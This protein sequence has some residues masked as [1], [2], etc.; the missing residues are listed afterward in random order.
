MTNFAHRWLPLFLLLA[1]TWMIPNLLAAETKN[2]EPGKIKP[3]RPGSLDDSGGPDGYGYRY[4]DNLNGDT[5][6]YNWIELRGDPAAEWIPFGEDD[7]DSVLPVA[8]GFHFPFYGQIFDTVYLSTNGNLQFASLL[9]AYSNECLPAA[10]IPGPA[11]FAYWDD[12]DLSR[13][14]YN[15]GGDVT[16]GIRR[17]TEG[18]VIEFDSVGHHG[19]DGTS[20]K[21][22]AFL[23]TDGSVSL[24]YKRMIFGSEINTQTIGIQ[25]GS[26]GPALQYVC[27][28]EG[29][30]PQD[31]LAILFYRVPTGTLR[32]LVRDT[33][34]N[35]VS[36]ADARIVELH[37]TAIT[38]DDGAYLFPSVPAGTYSVS[39]Y[40]IGYS[41]YTAGPV[42]ILA[43]DTTTLNVNLTFLGVFSFPSSDVPRDIADF[44]T[45]TSVLDVDTSMQIGDLDVLLN[46]QH[47]YDSDLRISLKAP[48][49]DTVVLTNREGGT[50]DNYINSVF[51]D[52]ADVPISAGVPPFTGRFR[53]EEPLAR[54]NGMNVQ[55]QWIL[56]VEDLAAGDTGILTSWEMDVTP[57]A[58]T[59]PPKSSPAPQ[60]FALLGNFPNPFNSTTEIRFSLPRTMPMELVLYNLLGQRVRTLASGSIEAGVHVIRWNGCDDHGKPL[61]SGLYFAQLKNSRTS[62]MAKLMLLH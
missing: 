20:F 61:S 44:D 50:G 24:Q 47:S 7:D 25:A 21:F 39:V 36:L 22:E 29:H 41:G 18:S 37:A 46:L 30:Q 45:T 15:P 9:D 60:Q 40:H 32:G 1:L 16:V 28:A 10:T 5:A 42:V 19:V 55:G 51:D 56:I 33:Q 2:M 58:E 27:S 53:P 23:R 43:A 13:G 14:G 12:L 57:S 34:G 62:S 52:Q 48:E 38:G 3:T 35:P 6:S 26:S 49:G 59:A 11:I 8:L 31:S 17:F 54:L 4:V